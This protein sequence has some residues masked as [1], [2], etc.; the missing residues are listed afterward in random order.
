MTE[1]SNPVWKRKPTY[2]LID[3]LN[4]QQQIN[5]QDLLKHAREVVSGI[6]QRRKFNSARASIEVEKK[7]PL[8]EAQLELV[9]RK[10][11]G[12]ISHE[13]FIQEAK[14]LTKKETGKDET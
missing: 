1:E 9:K 8:S 12:T 7:E 14:L 3:E 13:E 5:T 10:V 4:R 6:K 11:E 2:K